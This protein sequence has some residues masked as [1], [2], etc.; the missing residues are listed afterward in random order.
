VRKHA[1]KKEKDNAK[2]TI[3][4]S[5]EFVSNRRRKRISQNTQHTCGVPT[6]SRFPE[7]SG[8]VYE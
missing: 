1:R 2:H 8:H 4:M 3:Y 5:L 6:I 7:I